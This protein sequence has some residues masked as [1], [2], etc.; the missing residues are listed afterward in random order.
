[1]ISI[2]NAGSEKD[3]AFSEETLIISHSRLLHLGNWSGALWELTREKTD[4][5]LTREDMRQSGIAL[6][7]TSLTYPQER[8]KLILLQ[9]T[10]TF[11]LYNL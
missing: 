10:L 8:S 9:V 11:Y 6:K 5:L 2:Q 4:P 7:S 1:M 3:V